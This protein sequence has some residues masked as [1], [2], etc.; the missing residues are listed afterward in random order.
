L[1]E[2]EV[3]QLGNTSQPVLIIGAS[4]TLGSAF[5]RLC[6][7]RHIPYRLVGRKQLNITD[8][9][10]IERAI[11]YYNPW[12]V[13]N[14]AGYVKVDEAEKD[15]EACHL[16][17]T[18]GAMLL[19]AACHKR[20]IQFLTFSSDLVFDGIKQ[21]PY[22]EGD[23]VN[24]LN[25]YG[26]S[27]AQAERY[28]LDMHPQALVVRSSSFFGPWDNFNFLTLMVNQLRKGNAYLAP[29]DIIIS[30]TYVPDL[31]QA[32]LDLLV[33]EESGI[34]HLTNEGELSWADLARQGAGIV[35]LSPHLIKGFSA[36]ELQGH[37]A[38]RPR[39]SAL[40]SE[41]GQLLPSLEDALMRYANRMKLTNRIMISA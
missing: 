37:Q 12:A 7:D 35:G 3:H 30:P 16:I 8:P 18:H 4:G 6:G 13:I 23:V 14:T 40:S 33:D 10:S 17:N 31:V 24:P 2:R 19:A 28:V 41:R 25:V 34:W 5:A 26:K 39:Y 9:F 32:C 1:T 29:E 22:T 15:P 20:N 21:Q 38:P 11:N 36:N 27:K